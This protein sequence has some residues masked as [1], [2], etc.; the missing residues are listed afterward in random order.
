MQEITCRVPENRHC[1]EC[2]LSG[3]LE[4]QALKRA[5]HEASGFVNDPFS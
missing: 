3:I 4:A 2:Q 5:E 1:I